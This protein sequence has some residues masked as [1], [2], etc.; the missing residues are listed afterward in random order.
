MG[1]NTYL[2]NQ[3]RNVFKLPLT[4]SITPE[5]K[6]VK[7]PRCGGGNIHRLTAIGGAPLYNG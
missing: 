6:E 2:C 5:K 4:C 1:D 3:Y 7:C